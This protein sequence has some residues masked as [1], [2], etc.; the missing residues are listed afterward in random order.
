[1]REP[2]LKV[3]RNTF[4]LFVSSGEI[5]S[6]PYSSLIKLPFDG[7]GVFVSV[8]EKIGSK[9]RGKHGSIFPTKKSILDSIQYHTIE[10]AKEFPFRKNDLPLLTY[11][12]S[13]ISSPK[14][15]TDIKNVE[16][17][18]GF[19]VRTDRGKTAF[20][21]PTH[22]IKTP[23][24]RLKELCSKENIDLAIHNVRLYKFGIKKINEH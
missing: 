4:E 11:E 16:D 8:L 17:E 23:E 18:E 24:K 13:F 5:F 15:I 2:L 22:S 12:I 19:L 10:I 21:L 20:S 1:M 7:T 9:P 3:A 6:P 14:L